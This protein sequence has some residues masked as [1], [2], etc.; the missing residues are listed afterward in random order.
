MGK[1]RR[2]GTKDGRKEGSRQCLMRGALSVNPVFSEVNS[3][4]LLKQAQEV[5]KS[6]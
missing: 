3:I 6:G 2:E 4:N 1:G 5:Y